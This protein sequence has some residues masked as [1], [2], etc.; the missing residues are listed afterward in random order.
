MSGIEALCGADREMMLEFSRLCINR[1]HA[2]LPLRLLLTPFQPILEAN[3]LKEIEKDQ[4]IIR[5]AATEHAKGRA[6]EVVNIDGLFEATKAIDTVFLNTL[7][8]PFISIDIRYDDFEEIRKKRIAA[9]VTLAFNLLNNWNDHSSFPEIVRNTF[10]ENNYRIRLG[11]VLHLY[12]AETRML[13][14]SAILN[15]PAGRI[16]DLFSEKLFSTMEKT[17]G[18]ISAAYARNIFNGE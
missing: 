14:N 9:F 15:G 13:G 3:V 7:S 5:H 18:D 8:N 4:L 2:S 12:N 17:A 10:S 11:E 6:R 16:K 1:L